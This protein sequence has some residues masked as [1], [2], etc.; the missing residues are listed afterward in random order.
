MRHHKNYQTR[1]EC[2][3]IEEKIGETY[4]HHLKGVPEATPQADG[5]PNDAH[6]A[7]ELVVEEDDTEDDVQH[8][9]HVV[10]DEERRGRDKTL[11]AKPSSAD[12]EPDHARRCNHNPPRGRYVRQHL[13]VL[14]RLAR[15]HC[16]HHQ[17][18]QAQC[19]VVQRHC[20]PEGG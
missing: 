1:K 7:W 20:V 5:A 10:D 2:K 19:V 9:G 6:L 8:L 4:P 14:L 13:L 16:D 15:Q 18:R 12:H 3:E 17:V 11:Q